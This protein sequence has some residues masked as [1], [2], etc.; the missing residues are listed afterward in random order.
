[1]NKKILLYL[2]LSV[3]TLGTY[4]YTR[5]RQNLNLPE[6]AA[7]GNLARVQELMQGGADANISDTDRRTALLR[8]AAEEKL[9]VLAYL[10]KHGADVNLPD[11]D[12][13]TP[14]IEAA[15]DG[16]STMVMTLIAHGAN[17]NAQN[18]KNETALYQAAGAGWPNTVK[19]LIGNAADANLK[20]NDNQTPLYKAVQG[21]DERIR[22]NNT[23]KTALEKRYIK[24]AQLLLPKTNKA[25]VE[26][27][28]KVSENQQMQQLIQKYL[29]KKK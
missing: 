23:N 27:A 15:H 24:V 28:L 21:L 1:M 4:M 7:A 12:G 2:S 19:V 10:I 13:N 29:N 9:E 22:T 20:N 8:A 6:A 25:A 5:T 18:N 17:I 3:C 14:L 16:S 11:E 26:Q